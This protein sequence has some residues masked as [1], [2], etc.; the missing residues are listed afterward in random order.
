[1]VSIRLGFFFQLHVIQYHDSLWM[2][3]LEWTT[4]N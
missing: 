3:N 2:K 4:D 1:M